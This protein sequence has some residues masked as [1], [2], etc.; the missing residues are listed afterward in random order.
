MAGNF[1]AVSF[2]KAPAFEDG[3]AGYSDP[4]NEQNFV[5]NLINFLQKSPE[6]EHTAV[7]ITWDDSDGWYDHQMGP[8][9]NQSTSPADELTGTGACGDGSTA[10]PGP[11]PTVNAHA[12]G[13]CGYG[14]RIPLVVISPWAKH[15]FVNHNVMDFTSIIRFV[16]DNWLGGQR[17]PGGSFDSFANSLNGMFDFDHDGGDNDRLFLDPSTGQVLNEYGNW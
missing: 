11:D 13:R 5:V 9:V 14:P 3:H 10:L 1:P 4:L 8:I 15:N 16:E 12:Q 7:V 6:W 17:I 2:L